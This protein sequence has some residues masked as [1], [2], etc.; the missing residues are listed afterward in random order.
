MQEESRSKREGFRNHIRRKQLDEIFAHERQRILEQTI[1]QELDEMARIL[2]T[3][4]KRIH[5]VNAI[6]S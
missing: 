1:T 4:E 2:D 5:W 6:R 3:P